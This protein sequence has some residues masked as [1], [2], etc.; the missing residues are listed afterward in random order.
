MSFYKLSFVQSPNKGWVSIASDS[1][2]VPRAVQRLLKGESVVIVSD[3]QID[4]IVE[5]DRAIAK[6]ANIIDC[7][8][9]PVGQ[10]EYW[11]TDIRH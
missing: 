5:W 7:S 9:F 11:P 8:G 2:T 1:S 4:A 6:D 3:R 10:L